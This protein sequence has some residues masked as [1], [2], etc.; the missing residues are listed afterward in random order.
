M[1]TRHHLALALICALIV[2][3]PLIFSNPLIVAIIGA[4]TCLGAILPDIHMSRPKHFSLRTLA[5]GVVQIPKIL[6]A[7]ALGRIYARW[8]DPISDPSDKRLTHSL[9]GVL[10]IATCASV[11]LYIPALLANSA[12]AGYIGLFLGGIFLGMGLHLAEDLCT[13]K[14]IFPFFPFSVMK[15]AG[16]IRP[17]DQKDSRITRYH[18][19]GCVVLGI[20]ILVENSGL[21]P[22]D[23]VF[24]IS[25]TGLAACLGIMIYSS[26]VTINQ[27]PAPASR[28]ATYQTS[29]S[30]GNLE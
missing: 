11:F 17:C 7:L 18:I 2:F 12:Y 16:S 14:G 4:G 21:I 27:D 3:S 28:P 5:W 15:V 10:F 25:I 22:P 1:I 6:C 19:Q 8:G 30:D 24:L 26:D 9:P 29:Q 20:L 13:R 23:L